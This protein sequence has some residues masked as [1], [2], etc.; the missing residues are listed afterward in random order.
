MQS[1]ICIFKQAADKLYGRSAR[2]PNTT[3]QKHSQ[4]TVVSEKP[5]PKH[6]NSISGEHDDEGLIEKS[7]RLIKTRE[8]DAQTC[9]NPRICAIRQRP[10]IL[11]ILFRVSPH[12]ACLCS[13]R[14]GT[15]RAATLCTFNLFL[16]FVCLLSLFPLSAEISG[17]R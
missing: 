11:R 2:Q 16:V 6:R 4:Y 15:M 17:E 8:T 9:G 12:S 14:K 3:Q 7:S 5:T 1:Q 10:F 13:L